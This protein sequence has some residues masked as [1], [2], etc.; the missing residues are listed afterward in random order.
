MDDG[1]IR[2]NASLLES[3]HK[4]IVSDDFTYL[5]L[6]IFL[7]FMVLRIQNIKL[8]FVHSTHFIISFS[9]ASRRSAL[10]IKIRSATFKSAGLS[11]L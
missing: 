7:Q 6:N 9:N 8:L 11:A 1:E 5:G 4:E 2:R 3:K 10:K